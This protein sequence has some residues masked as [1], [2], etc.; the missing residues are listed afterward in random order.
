MGRGYKYRRILVL[1]CLPLSHLLLCRQAPYRPQISTPG[2]GF[3]DPDTKHCFSSEIDFKQGSWS[4]L[5]LLETNNFDPG[6]EAASP[7][8]P[9]LAG[10]F[11][12]AELPGKPSC[13]LYLI[14]HGY[15]LP[16]FD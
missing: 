16:Q 13:W 9:E 2:Q 5:Q 3:G 4:H 6:M 14:P 7:A 11:F 8:V 1:P 12:T 10:G 15:T